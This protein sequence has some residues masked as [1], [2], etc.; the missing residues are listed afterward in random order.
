MRPWPLE[1]VD[2]I[3]SANTLHFMSLD[4][5]EDFFRG[6]GEVLEPGG[7]LAVYGPFRYRG[8]FT[9]DSNAQFD[10]WL[11]QTDPVRGV[12]DFEWI[13]GLAQ[14]QGLLLLSDT[15]MPANN[16]LLLWQRSA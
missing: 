7:R 1:P 11:K 4:C 5:A 16:Q 9:S 6:V 14:A 13:D 8:E 2:A 12:R 10:L 3:F 15:L